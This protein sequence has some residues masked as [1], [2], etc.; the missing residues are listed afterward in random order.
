MAAPVIALITDFGWKDGYVGAMKGVILSINP[1]CQIIDVAHEIEAHDIVGAALVLESVYSYFPPRSIFLVI[2]DPGV[3]GSRKG[4]VVKAADKFLVGP[5]NGVFSLVLQGCAFEAYEIA[6]ERYMLPKVSSTFH[7]RDVFAP[8]AAHLTIGVRPEQ[9]GP[10][11]DP[12]E[13]KFIP[14]PMPEKHGRETVGQVIYVDRFGNLITNL[15]YEDLR[16]EEVI[17]EVEGEEIQEI[18]RTYEDGSPGEVIAL[19][20]SHGRLELAIREQ[21]LKNIKGWSVGTQVKV[22]PKSR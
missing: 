18:K 5:D 10:R 11:L 8:V 22:K 13:L 1:S 14:M 21:S 6:E 2:V 19:W 12:T 17:I 9:V 3:G 20:G 16:E 7:G 15:R 4:I